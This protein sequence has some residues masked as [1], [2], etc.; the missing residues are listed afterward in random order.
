MSFSQA[1]T[2]SKDDPYVWENDQHHRIGN[3]YDL[4]WK[5]L[6][7]SLIFCRLALTNDQSGWSNYICL[8]MRCHLL[9][10]PFIKSSMPT[11]YIASHAIYSPPF[12]HHQSQKQNKKQ[13]KKSQNWNS[14]VNYPD[15]ILQGI[16]L[17]GAHFLKL[18]SLHF[19]AVGIIG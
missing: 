4:I 3:V 12:P 10:L 6:V 1:V 14:D 16:T 18:L 8:I 19:Q 13:N 17:Q 9:N 5:F 2:Q 15:G 11:L 7:F